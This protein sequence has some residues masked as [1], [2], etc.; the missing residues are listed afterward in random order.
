M[1]N[2]CRWRLSKVC[3]KKNLDSLKPAGDI[4]VD[5][6]L[7]VVRSVRQDLPAQIIMEERYEEAEQYETLC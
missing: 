1:A 2:H 7:K 3:S 6:H 5:P 4:A